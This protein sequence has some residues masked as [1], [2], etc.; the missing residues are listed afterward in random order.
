MLRYVVRTIDHRQHSA[1]L[2]T[3]LS[4]DSAMIV[5]TELLTSAAGLTGCKRGTAEIAEAATKQ[6]Q[7]GANQCPGL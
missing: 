3:A 6:N 5:G 2:R 1:I 4:S 7:S